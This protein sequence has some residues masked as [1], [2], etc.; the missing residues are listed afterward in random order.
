MSLHELD[1]KFL[2]EIEHF[3]VSYNDARGKKFKPLGR[4]GP[5]AAKRLIKKQTSR[6]K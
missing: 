3:F 2:G 1:S 6:R 4:K 5:A